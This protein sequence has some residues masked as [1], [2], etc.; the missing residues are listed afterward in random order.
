MREWGKG[1]S[2][3]KEQQHKTLHGGPGVCEDMQLP[4]VAGV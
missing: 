2:R 3:H 1:G 4:H